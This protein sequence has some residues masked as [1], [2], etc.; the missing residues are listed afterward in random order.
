M[1]SM[2][3]WSRLLAMAAIACLLAFSCFDLGQRFT[4]LRV[5]FQDLIDRRVLAFLRAPSLT[6]SGARG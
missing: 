5:Q 6:R 3:A 1:A 4:P 2:P